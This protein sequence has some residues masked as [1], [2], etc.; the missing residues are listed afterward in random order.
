VVTLYERLVKR[1]LDPIESRHSS[2]LQ[3]GC[4]CI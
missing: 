1:T 2:L 4:Q 3:N